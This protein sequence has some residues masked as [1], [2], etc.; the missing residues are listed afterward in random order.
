MARV[1]K[2]NRLQM[3]LLECHLP[4][5]ELLEFS[6]AEFISVSVGSVGGI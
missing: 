6:N 2:N 3:F 4:T 1:K 5:D